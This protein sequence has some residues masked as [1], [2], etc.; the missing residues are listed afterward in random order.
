MNIDIDNDDGHT[1]EEE[2][3]NSNEDEG[4]GNDLKDDEGVTDE[5]I[6]I[7]E[8][9]VKNRSN[10]SSDK[11]AVGVIA[12]S[13]WIEPSPDHLNFLKN[14]QKCLQ[15]LK[16]NTKETRKLLRDSKKD[17]INRIKQAF[18]TEQHF[19]E[20]KLL[21]ICAWMGLSYRMIDRNRQIVVCISA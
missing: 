15:E 12:I 19:E 7:F 8:S 5:T 18:P 11:A 13:E 1:G 4:K 9:I 2:V 20:H 21:I 17:Y 10:D 14:H 3:L 16:K 6:E